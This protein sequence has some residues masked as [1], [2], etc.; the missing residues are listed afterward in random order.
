MKTPLLVSAT[1][2]FAVVTTTIAS[3]ES[4][5]LLQTENK[6]WESIKDKS[7]TAIEKALATDFRGVYSDS[8]NTRDQELAGVKKIDLKSFSISGSNV[9][10]IDQ[11]AA[12]LTY[13][14][15]VTGTNDG[16]DIS[17]KMRA[18][19]VWRKHG[20]DWQAVYHTDVK[21]E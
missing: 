2:L 4:D 8:I 1:L 13:N 16:K 15:E 14:V 11:D 7:Y 20:N 19:S 10:M 5:A 17:G 21:A 18:A 9:T 6:V 3:P 12:L